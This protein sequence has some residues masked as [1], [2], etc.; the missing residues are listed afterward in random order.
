MQSS[1][2]VSWPGA[3]LIIFVFV[4]GIICETL[5]NRM[6]PE[7]VLRSMMRNVIPLSCQWA[8][9]FLTID[10]IIEWLLSI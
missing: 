10:F 8:G 5:S 3:C 6:D 1:G 7:T 4:I 9:L 2:F